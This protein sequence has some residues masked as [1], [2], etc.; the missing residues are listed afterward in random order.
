MKVE[1][2]ILIAFLG[3]YLINNDVAGLASLIPGNPA[4]ANPILTAQYGAFA[5]LAMILIALMAWWYFRGAKADLTQ[6]VIFGAVGFLAMVVTAFNTG[7]SGILVQ[8]GSFAEVAPILPQFFTYL[9]NPSLPIWQQTTAIFLILWMAP[10]ILMGWYL[11]RSKSPAP[12]SSPSS[13]V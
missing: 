4:A 11:G 7:V 5:I 1:R 12:M 10:S 6:G 8:T 9:W 3:N 2:M 13:M